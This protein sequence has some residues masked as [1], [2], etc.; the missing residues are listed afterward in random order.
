MHDGSKHPDYNAFCLDCHQYEVPSTETTSMNPNTTSGYL[1]AIDW[2]SS[3][4]MHG[5]RPR[6]HEVT[7]GFHGMTI[8]AP[9]D[10]DTP[11][12]NYIL[13]CLDC[14]EPHGTVLA[15]AHEPSSYLLRKEAN[16]NSVDGCG[17]LPENFCESDFCLSCHGAWANPP[18]CGGPQGCFQCHYH[19]ATANC[20]GPWWKETF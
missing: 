3:G 12:S 18:H 19:G 13:S 1:S 9:Y 15:S 7:G 2:S 8:I 17:P 11:P 10:I 16:N 20:R 6:Y 4:D 14:H 5:G